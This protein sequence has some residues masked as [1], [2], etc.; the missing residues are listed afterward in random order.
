MSRSYHRLPDCPV[1]GGVGEVG[2]QGGLPCDRCGGEGEVLDLPPITSRTY[3]FDW[4]PGGGPI[5]DGVDQGPSK[6]KQRVRLTEA[7]VTEFENGEPPVVNTKAV[8]VKANGQRDMRYSYSTMAGY[9][10][11]RAILAA[12]RWEANRQADTMLRALGV[13]Q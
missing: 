5:V 2:G 3:S 13:D 12:F 6:G 7:T 1:C 10:A 9:E 4:P 8:V 11:S